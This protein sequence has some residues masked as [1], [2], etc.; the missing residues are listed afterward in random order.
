MSRNDKEQSRLSY[1]GNHP[2]LRQGAPVSLRKL[3]ATRQA[4]DHARDPLI[5]AQLRDMEKPESQRQEESGR[6]SLMVRLDRPFPDL[7]PK[8]DKSQLRCSFNQ[9]WMREQRAAVMAQ[10]QEQRAN[11]QQQEE[12]TQ[13]V[14]QKPTR[15]WKP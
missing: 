4:F 12:Q 14:V 15:E 5:S 6:G 11:I 2:D 8:D 13:E 10:F 7:R 9:A 1:S 3:R